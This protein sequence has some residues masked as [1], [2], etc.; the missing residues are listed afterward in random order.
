MSLAAP[1]LL[2]EIGRAAAVSGLLLSPG[3]AAVYVQ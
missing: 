1:D 2:L 3:L